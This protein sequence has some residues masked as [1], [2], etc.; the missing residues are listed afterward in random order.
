MS[1]L[2]QNILAIHSSPAICGI[3]A[4]NLINL[5]ITDELYEE[6]EELNKKYPNLCFYVLKN[7]GKNALIL[8]Y[9]KKVLERYLFKEENRAFLNSIGYETESVELIL[10]SLRERMEE[11]SFPHEIGVFLGYDLSDIKSFIEGKVCLYVG[12][13]KVYSKVEEKMEIFDK[14][15]RCNNAVMRMIDK[16]YPIEN[17]MR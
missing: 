1:T 14:H 9:R 10:L 2:L 7:D 13:W 5:K 12:Y 17:Y 8:V 16:G 4:S 15:T 6:I 11:D 3:K